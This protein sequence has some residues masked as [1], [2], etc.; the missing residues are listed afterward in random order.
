MNLPLFDEPKQLAWR[1]FGAAAIGEK[2]FLARALLRDVQRRSARPDRHDLRCGIRGIGRDVLEFERHDVDATREG[3]N[4]LD[5]VERRADFEIRDLSGG[6]VDAWR[7]G[8]QA[9]AHATRGERE[10][11]A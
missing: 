4:R 3:A 5:V 10:H 9:I 6:R 1:H 11:A 7:K 2:A 8:M